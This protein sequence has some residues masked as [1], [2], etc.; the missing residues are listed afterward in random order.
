MRHAPERHAAVAAQVR[1]AKWVAMLREQSSVEEDVLAVLVAA[2]LSDAVAN[3]E[4]EPVDVSSAALLK[5]LH[6]F[7][8]GHEQPPA[9]PA[10]VRQLPAALPDGNLTFP[11]GTLCSD[12]RLD[13]CKQVIGPDGISDLMQSLRMDAASPS[14]LVQ[15][16]LLGNNIA[17]DELAARIAGLIERGESRLTTWYIAGN[18]LTAN[19]IAPLCRAL[20]KDSPSQ[21]IVRQLWLKRNPLRAAGALEL[22]KLL[23]SNR[24]LLALDLVCTAMLDEGVSNIAKALAEAKSPLQHLYLDGNGIRLAGCQALAALLRE[25]ASALEGLG[26]GCNRVGD[27]GAKVLAAA[28]PCNTRLGKLGLGSCGIG[29]AG[30]D[31]LA[32]ALAANCA[33]RWLDLGFLKM[34]RLLLI[35]S[36]CF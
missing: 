18:R 27:E 25:P 13:L 21:R 29:R 20:A 5:P 19:G 8:Q 17:G 16:L 35:A 1:Q 6:T 2:P 11:R 24:H 9:G 3:P 34:T 30:A 23:L 22:G 32:T 26:L 4:P 12:G 33:L 14:P 10:A 31:A 28:L 36:D 7:L 15:H